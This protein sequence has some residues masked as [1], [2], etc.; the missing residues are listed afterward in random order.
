MEPVV[1]ALTSNERYFPELYCAV[2]RALSH[3]K[4]TQGVLRGAR[5]RYF[6][7]VQG[8]ERLATPQFLIPKGSDWR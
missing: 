1:L 6:S 2:A 5:R 8:L 4:P 7:S 3:L